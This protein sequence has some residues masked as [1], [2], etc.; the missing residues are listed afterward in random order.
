MMGAAGLLL[1]VLTALRPATALVVYVAV[2][3]LLV[4][5]GRGALVPGLRL[6]EVLLGALLTG[7]VPALLKRW[8][9]A[10][11]RRPHGFHALDLVVLGLA[12]AASVSPLLWMYARSRD[13]TTD[14]LLYA[15]ALWKLAILYALV[16]LFVRDG[17]AMRGLLTAV[18]MT[19]LIIGAVGVLQALGI[20]PVIDL[21]RTWIPPEE[22]GYSI[23]NNRGTS[24]LGN[25][26]AYG[27]LML[28]ATA[29]AASLAVTRQGRPLA[30]AVTGALAVGALGSGQFSTVLGL[31]V[32]GVAFAIATRTGV[33][34]TVAGALLLGTALVAFQP[35]LAARQSATD[36][37]SGL[38]L[39]W[40][41]DYGR[42]TNL[43]EHFWPVI[44]A[45][46]NWLFG[47]QPAARVPGRETW[48]PWIYIESGY[49]WVLWTG[50]IPMLG[51]V[52]ALLVVMVNTGRRLVRS[53]NDTWSAIGLAL[54]TVSWVLGVLMLFDPHLT[55][56]GGADLLFVLLALGATCRGPQR[57]RAPRPPR[58]VPLRGL[59]RGRAGNDATAGTAN[60]LT[61]GD[62]LG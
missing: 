54:V 16:R 55:L 35:V 13:I 31:V 17:R 21:L 15:L 42:L 23:D 32:G 49:T 51:A 1:A 9:D 27:D 36:P 61:G 28:Y 19:S 4:G 59:T 10:G 40:T 44:A 11:W 20:G 6:N 52:V 24:T 38:P 43:Q 50:G 25:P 62:P 8:H 3:P 34:V 58:P 48:D 47:V 14:D 2:N 5:L 26:I 56:R 46:H 41:G 18:L 45:D 33:R 39:S 29:T 22:G 60:S 30:W 53:T 37:Q 57:H 7:L 12:V